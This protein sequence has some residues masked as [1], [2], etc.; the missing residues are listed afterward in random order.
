MGCSLVL[1]TTSPVVMAYTV[2]LSAQSCS[3]SY[4]AYNKTDYGAAE[5]ST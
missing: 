5:A 3:N 4:G 1:E 2:W